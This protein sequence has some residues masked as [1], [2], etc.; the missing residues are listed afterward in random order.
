MYSRET[1]FLIDSKER[2]TRTVFKGLP[3][4]AVLSPLLYAIYTSDISEGI[5]EDIKIIQF[6]DDIAIYTGRHHRQR[7]KEKLEEAVNIIATRL[8]EIELDL[9]PH[10]TELVEFS[11]H[12]NID[13]NMHINIKNTRVSNKKEAKFLGIWLDNK[14]QFQKQIQEA[15]GKIFRANSIKYI[16]GVFKGMEVNTALMLY[17]SIV[18]SVADYGVMF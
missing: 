17:K 2:T 16:N 11:K 3:Q 8:E 4:G 14:L 6:A 7:N 18:R 13:R 9:Q 5:L 10:K 1:E 15:R 12:E